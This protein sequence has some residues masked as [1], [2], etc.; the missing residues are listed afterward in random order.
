MSEPLN[1]RVIIAMRQAADLY[2]RLVLLVGPPASGKTAT[3]REVS[4]NLNVASMNVSL[5][6]SK[7]MLE[8]TD[9]QRA[10]MASGILDQIAS[11]SGDV[12]LLDN[13][14]ILFSTALKLD[15]LRL[16]QNISRNRT[17][18]ANWPGTVGGGGLHYAIS[19]H[20]EYRRYSI[21]GLLIVTMQA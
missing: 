7:R 21:S 12:A 10:L 11:N 2:H 13:I 16:L 9:R 4:R 18:V 5:E 6:I 17:V 14:E 1:E 8:L 3:L 19:G 20:P 15:P